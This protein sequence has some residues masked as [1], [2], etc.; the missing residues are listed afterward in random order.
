MTKTELKIVAARLQEIDEQLHALFAR[1][2]EIMDALTQE[3]RNKVFDLVMND[4][5]SH[6]C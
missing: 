2:K 4:G 1:R 3:E 6:Y 5:K